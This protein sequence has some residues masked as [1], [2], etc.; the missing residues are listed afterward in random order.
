MAA[1]FLAKT[2]SVAQ[3]LWRQA[4]RQSNLTEQKYLP[5]FDGND[6][7]PLVWHQAISESPSATSCV[8]TIQ[9]F[10]VGSG[11]TDQELEKKIV[12]LKGETFFQ[13]HQK[14]CDDYAE[15][16]GFAI[17]VIYNALGKIVGM[18]QLPFEN[19]RLGPPDS[20]GYIS[21]ILYNPYFGTG[22]YQ[23]VNKNTCT[24]DSFNPK[25]D[26]VKSQI[27]EQGKNY[28]GQVLFFGTTTALSRFYPMP[29]AHA[30]MKW[31]KIERGVSDYHEDNINNGFL[32]PFMLAMIGNP[33][34]PINNPTEGEEPVSRGQAFDE[35]VSKNFMGAKRVGN[36][37]VSWFDNKDELPVPIA[38]PSNNTGDLFLNVDTQATK[39]ITIAFKVPAILANINEGVSLGG[40]GNTI[41]VAVKLMQTRLVDKQRDLTDVYESI[42]RNWDTPYTEEIGIKPYHPYPELEILDDK[43]WNAMTDDERR[44]WITKH[45][46]IDLSTGISEPAPQPLQPA[47]ARLT[48][49]NAIPVSFPEPVI[50]NIKKTLAYKEKMEVKCGSRGG[51]ELAQAVADNK[52]LGFKD[53]KRIFNYLN[54]NIRYENSPLNEGCGPIEYNLWGGK[55]MR[56]FLT[57][58]FEEIDVW[59]NK[60]N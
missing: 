44:D 15:F 51:L 42:L 48:I 23:T 31:M 41:R 59:L 3:N 4:T 56:E 36:M 2:Y 49:T 47:Q 6:N 12:N 58:K 55:A 29:E 1:T 21:K 26:I 9:S 10:M 20:N 57:A 18:E 39:K 19:V 34:E 7:F 11:F 38:F 17:R 28:R 33:N 27:L 24:Y 60:T 30:A 37:W 14:I 53:L 35:F 13:V 43:I 52:N 22:D 32:Q 25:L 46:D 54:R 45:T 8:S 50:S 40:D 5:Y 16:E